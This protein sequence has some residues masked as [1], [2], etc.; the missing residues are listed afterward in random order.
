M[1]GYIVFALF[2]GRLISFFVSPNRTDG[3]CSVS[4]YIPYTIPVWI[5]V[6]KKVCL[7]VQGVAV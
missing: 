2:F 5:Y 3:P 7:V 1:D 4:G 6:Q